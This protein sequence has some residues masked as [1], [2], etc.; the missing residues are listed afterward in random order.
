M[1]IEGDSNQRERLLKRLRH[2]SRQ[3]GFAEADRIFIA[4]AE[5]HLDGL[6]DDLLAQ[7]EALLALPDWDTFGWISGQ[8]EPPPEFHGIVGSMRLAIGKSLRA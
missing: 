8:A 1:E 5:R 4:F 2:R 7:Y 3:R 6:D